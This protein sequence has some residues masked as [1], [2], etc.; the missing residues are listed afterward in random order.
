MPVIKIIC[1]E[2]ITRVVSVIRV[3]SMACVTFVVE[4][5]VL[6]YSFVRVRVIQSERYNLLEIIVYCRPAHR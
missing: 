3:N 1:Y 4:Q 2:N 5:K 6:K